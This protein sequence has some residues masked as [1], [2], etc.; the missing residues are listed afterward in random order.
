MALASRAV[1]TKHRDPADR[2][3]IATAQVFYLTLV[4]A[5][6][7]LYDI[8]G[9]RVLKNT[10]RRQRRPGNVKAPPP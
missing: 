1:K 6:R 2:F 4:T 9:V 5:D 8:P 10:P 3:L 7:A